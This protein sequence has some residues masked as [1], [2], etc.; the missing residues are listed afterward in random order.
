MI[1]EKEKVNWKS[2][3]LIG[4]LEKYISALI[5]F[6]CVHIFS[7]TKNSHN[8]YCCRSRTDQ[9]LDLK[10][11]KS[12]KSLS[13]WKQ[14][15]CVCVCVQKLTGRRLTLTWLAA[16]KQAASSAVALS[17]DVHLCMRY[18][19]CQKITLFWAHI[20]IY[21]L[22]KKIHS[23]LNW[24]ANSINANCWVNSEQSWQT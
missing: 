23:S 3:R 4:M 6:T 1:A 8:S 16:S 5:L 22:S 10:W 24:R 19:Y 18:T 9:Q 7:F 13:W 21:T 14:N 17:A 20:L 2:R 11:T 15:V 12:V